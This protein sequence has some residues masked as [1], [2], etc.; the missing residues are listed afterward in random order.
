MGQIS[1]TA[2]KG[3]QTRGGPAVDSIAYIVAGTGG[4]SAVQVEEALGSLSKNEGYCCEND[5]LDEHNCKRKTDVAVCSD[6][7]NE[8]GREPPLKSLALE[9]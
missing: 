4:I 6:E 5:K 9:K 2:V 1:I 7:K 3:E 8:W